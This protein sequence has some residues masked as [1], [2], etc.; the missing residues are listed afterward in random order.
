M[1]DGTE[2]GA[3]SANHLDG[4]AAYHDHPVRFGIVESLNT[5]IKR[6]PPPGRGMSDELMLLLK[7]KRATHGLF[8]RRRTLLVS[9][10]RLTRGTQIGEG[11]KKHARSCGRPAE[12]GHHDGG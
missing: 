12:S 3:A 4:I 5:T 2:F 7:L 10:R 9:C 6:C 8:D 11:R 1:F